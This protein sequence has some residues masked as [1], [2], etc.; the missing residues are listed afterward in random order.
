MYLIVGLGN[1]GQQYKNTVHN[2][3]FDAIDLISKTYNIEV[4]RIKF[5]G[6]YGEGFIKNKKVILLKPTTYMNCSGESI[7][8]V[9]NFYKI[10]L[11]DVIVIYDDISLPIG[12]MRIRSKGSAGGHNGIKSIIACLGTEEFSR[13]KIG[14]GQPQ[15]S[16]V[17]YVLSKLPKEER[18]KQEKIF[19]KC[20]QAVETIIESNI[21]DAMNKYNSFTV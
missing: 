11:E 17:S 13:I 12:K 21:T 7:I 1:P 20:V 14:V 6:I 19:D 9:V 10:P 16:L 4:N 5:K 8:E 15:H 18:E 3:G 2:T